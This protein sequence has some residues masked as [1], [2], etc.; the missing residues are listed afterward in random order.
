MTYNH[1]FVLEVKQVC[2]CSIMG[3]WTKVKMWI[4]FT[5][6]CIMQRKQAFT[7]PQSGTVPGDKT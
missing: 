5:G 2:S 1:V 3:V 7:A 6:A 4:H